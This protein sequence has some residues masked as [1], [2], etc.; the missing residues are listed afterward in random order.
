MTDNRYAAEFTIDICDLATEAEADEIRDRIE[1]AIA[2]WTPTIT[3][4]TREY[5]TP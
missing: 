2:A 3:A 1:D 4:S 5:P